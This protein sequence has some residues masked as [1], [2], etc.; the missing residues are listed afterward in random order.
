MLNIVRLAKGLLVIGHYAKGEP[1]IV[2]IREG[3]CIYETAEGGG[4][5]F[6]EMQVRKLRRYGFVPL[7]TEYGGEY[8]YL[9]PTFQEGEGK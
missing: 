2:A 8:C 9:F 7:P 6:N 3:L 1:V 5:E 4:F